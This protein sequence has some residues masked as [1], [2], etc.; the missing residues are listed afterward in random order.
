MPVHENSFDYFRWSIDRCLK[1]MTAFE[2]EVV[3]QAEKSWSFLEK[4]GI[5]LFFFSKK[6]KMASNPQ[7]QQSSS[8]S[9]PPSPLVWF[10]LLDAATG[11]PYK[12][13]TADYV[14]LA[15]GSFIAQFRDAA[16]LKNSSILTGI[17]SS[18]LLVYKNKDAF[19]KRNAPLEEKVLYYTK[20]R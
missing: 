7:Q 20:D 6:V 11:E 9:S 19:D 8:M 18:Q 4:N 13:T 2:V 5:F 16:H 10:L 12:K 15:P 1:W 14:S 17:A 3:S